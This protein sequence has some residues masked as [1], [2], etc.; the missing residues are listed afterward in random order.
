MLVFLF[1]FVFN[2]KIVSGLTKFTG[3]C[4][5]QLFYLPEP[6]SM[7]WDTESSCWVTNKIETIRDW[8]NHENHENHCNFLLGLKNNPVLLKLSVGFN[9]RGP[10]SHR[11]GFPPILAQHA[12]WPHY[13]TDMLTTQPVTTDTLSVHKGCEISPFLIWVNSRAI[14]SFQS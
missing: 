12:D 2:I 9:P 11:Y 13:Q 10:Q 8:E 1:C 4:Y 6:M 5:I 3:K 14:M 7:M